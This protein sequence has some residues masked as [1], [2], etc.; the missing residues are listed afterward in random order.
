MNLPDILQYPG[1]ILEALDL[2]EVLSDC[3]GYL[4]GAVLQCRSEQW[5]LT[6]LFSCFS[7]S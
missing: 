6:N 3:C 1:L 4:K 7:P 5:L 2:I